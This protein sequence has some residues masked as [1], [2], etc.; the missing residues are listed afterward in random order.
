ML[1]TSNNLILKK[2][3]IK[4]MISRLALVLLACSSVLAAPTINSEIQETSLVAT[5]PQPTSSP[6]EI[7]KLPTEILSKI[8]EIT[9]NK[10]SFQLGMTFY[11]L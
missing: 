11:L 8:V 9:D 6:L 5:L 10:T 7:M 3:I 2:K 4:I 1:R